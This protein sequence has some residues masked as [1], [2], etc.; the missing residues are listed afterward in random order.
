MDF[1]YLSTTLPLISNVIRY[2]M[3]GNHR[4]EMQSSEPAWWSCAQ[5]GFAME[6]AEEAIMNHFADEFSLFF[7]LQTL[8]Q[9][10]ATF[11]EVSIIWNSSV[12]NTHVQ[13]MG[14]C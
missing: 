13:I 4:E 8:C 9:Q 2:Y 6:K 5:F 3:H 11:S 1:Q 10:I 14:H 7:C 12:D